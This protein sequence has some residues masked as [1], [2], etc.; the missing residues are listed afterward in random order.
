VKSLMLGA[1]VASALIAGSGPNY[2]SDTGG[3]SAKGTTAP[4]TATTGYRFELTG[5]QRVDVGRS[6]VAI[7]LIRTTDNKPVIGAIIIQSQADLGPIGM[8]TTTASIKQLPS[9][10]PGI[11]RFEIAN[12]TVWNRLDKWALTFSAKVQGEAQVVRG[13]VIVQLSP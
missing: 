8:A 3:T 9:S 2:A 6:T 13:S 12:G 7:R 11:Y 5:P 1:V 10:T 4:V